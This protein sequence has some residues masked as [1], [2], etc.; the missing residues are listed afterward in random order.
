M[1]HCQIF[2]GMDCPELNARELWFK[3]TELI[4]LTIGRSVHEFTV[5][6]LKF[7]KN[8]NGNHGVCIPSHCGW[9]CNSQVPMLRP[10]QV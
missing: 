10:F 1:R 5:V 9:V 8:S 7:K 4:L 2:A 3:E 6:W